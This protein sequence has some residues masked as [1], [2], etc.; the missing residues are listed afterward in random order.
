MR[1]FLALIV[2]LC[3]ASTVNAQVHFGINF[4]LNSQPA[5][6]PTGYDY[7]ENYYFPD[8][9]VYYNVP[10]RRYYY[11][12]RGRWMN[13]SRLPSRFGSFDLYNSHK[14]VVNNQRPWQNHNTYRDKFSS[15]KG[16]RDQ[17]PIRDSRDSKYFANKYHPEHNNWVQQ[18]KRDNGNRN[19]NG[20]NNSNNQDGNKNK[21]DK[22][23]R[24]N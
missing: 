4:N 3:L 8:I 5:W 13:S 7:V 23:K 16:Q 10:T 9:E 12:E 20:R 15:F 6:G 1:Y 21:N 2:A 11:N 24:N 22:G 14:E 17:Q 18:Q 19:G